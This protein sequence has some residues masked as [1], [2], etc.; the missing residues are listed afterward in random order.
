MKTGTYDLGSLAGWTVSDDSAPLQSGTLDLATDE[1]LELQR[2]EGRD[3]TLDVRFT[4]FYEFLDGHVR[5]GVQR[6]VFEDVGFVSTRMQTQLWASLRSVIWFVRM[7]HP[8]LEVFAVPVGVLKHFATCN[9]HANKADMAR[10]LANHP[11]GA[12]ALNADGSIRK[13]DGSTAD[14]NEVDAI[15]LALYTQAVDQGQAR[16][17]T[18]HQRKLLKL[19][20]RREKKAARKLRKKA[21]KEAAEAAV[22]AKNQAMKNVIKSLGKCCGVFRRQS[23]RRAVCPHCGSSVPLPRLASPAESS[24]HPNGIGI[25]TKVGFNGATSNSILTPTP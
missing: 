10:A 9:L 4:R 3:R 7:M 16:F 19:Q 11:S 5:S 15:W 6:V 24:R 25:G 22:R 18:S 2:R 20:D 21:K 17:L 23:S 14:D 12:Y 1:E 8:S 13:P